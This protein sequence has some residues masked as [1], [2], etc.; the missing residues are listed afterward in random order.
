M[1]ADPAAWPGRERREPARSD[2]HYLV[3][4]PLAKQLQRALQ[5]Y[6]ATK[7][8]ADVLDVGCGV[9]PYLPL[10]GRRAATYRGLDFEPGPQVDDVGVAERL[11]YDDGSFDLLL[12][13]QAMEHMDDPSAAV[14][15]FA[16]VLRPGGLA[17]VS[18]HG[19]FLF[20]P[21]PPASDR[22]YWRWTHAGLERLFR[23]GGDWSRL[24]VEPS[25]E[26]IACLAYLAC[27]FVD[28]ALRRAA[29]DR[30]R[31]L[32]LSGLNATAAWLDARFPKHARFPR[33]GSIAANYLVVASK[34]AV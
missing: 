19:V 31:R 34:P 30:T 20:H 14:A 27:Q 26:V 22:D 11:P 7:E 32:A 18:T 10:V 2:P 24:Q 33:A 6:F 13:T 17:L 9:K 3:L 15:E 1:Q 29:L 4:A 12:C 25:G 5:D 16:R 28:A 8:Q 23:E 21:D